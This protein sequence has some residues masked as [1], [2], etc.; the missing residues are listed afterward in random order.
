[1]RVVC[2]WCKQ[3]GRDALLGECEPFDDKTETSGICIRHCEKMVEQLPSVT[4]PG[5]RILFVVR[6]TEATLYHH[7]T[8]LL[9]ELPDVAVILDRRQRERRETRSAAATERRRSNRRLRGARFSSLGYLVVRFRP[10]R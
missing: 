7:L 2:A 1:M 6:R 10:R 4:F 8:Q 9:V 5:I 3:E